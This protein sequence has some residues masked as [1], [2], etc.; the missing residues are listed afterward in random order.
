[1][2]GSHLALIALLAG[3]SENNITGPT[4]YVY[5]VNITT[6]L[7]RLIEANDDSSKESDNISNAF[8][9]VYF[10]TQDPKGIPIREVL[11]FVQTQKPSH[12]QHSNGTDYVDY[13]V[14]GVRILQLKKMIENIFPERKFH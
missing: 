14:S 5:P 2:K 10:D 7:P 11:A 3:C 13:F 1:M 9:P 6:K 4:D 12:I 8:F